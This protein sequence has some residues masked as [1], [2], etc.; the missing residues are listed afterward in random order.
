MRTTMFHGMELSYEV[1]GG[2]AVHDGDII[3]GTAEEAAARAPGRAEP[4]SPRLPRP[5]HLAPYP[6]E[7]L[8]P[9]G[10]IPYV[11]DDDVPMRHKRAVL[12]GIEAWDAKTVLTFVE[13]T[14]ER[15]YLRW[16]VR[17]EGG[18]S[19]AFGRGYDGGEQIMP[20]SPGG[21]GVDIEL[22][23]LGHAIGIWH[24]Q[25]RQDR[26]RY[27]RVFRR[28]IHN[29][30]NQWDQYENDGAD[31]GPYDYRSVMH[32]TFFSE[33]LRRHNQMPMAE[34]IPPGM[35][36][37]GHPEELSPGDID[38]VNRLYG[39][40]PAAWVVST[41]P[42]GLEIVV[43]GIR[44]TAPA[45]FDWEPDSE[46]TLEVPS[47]Q[48]RPGSR[49]LFGR[50]SDG[51]DR[52]HRITA[53]P[54]TTLFQ[55]SFVAQHQVSTSVEPSGAGSVVVSPASP[56][57]YYTLRSPVGLSATPAPG[58]AFRFLNWGVETDFP[59]DWLVW[60][61]HGRSSNP[62]R[63]YVTAG[64]AYRALFVDGP[65]VRIDSNVEQAR[66]EMD[67]WEHSTPVAFPA[68]AYADSGS[69][70]VAAKP[71]E[72]GRRSYRHRFRSWSDGGA[73][74][75]TVAVPQATDTALTLTLDTEYRLT[76]R[77]WYR[78]AGNEIATTPS[79]DDG[80]FA[81]GTEV[82]LRASAG[83]HDEFIGWFGD[84]S[85]HD[86]AV[87]VVMD[88]AQFAEAV[89]ASGRPKTDELQVDAPV[90]VAMRWDANARGWDL[91]G[92]KY[93]VRV[94]T[95]ASELEVEF[96]TRVATPDAVGG[97][98]LTHRS[99]PNWDQVTHENAD[100]VLRPGEVATIAIPRPPERWPAAYFILAR[101]A[102]STGSGTRMLEGTLVARVTGRGSYNRAPYPAGTL[103]DRTLVA[104][105]A[106]LVMDVARAFRDLD[107]DVLTYTAVSSAATVAGVGVWG[108]TLT[109]TPGSAGT[110]T[111]RV[112]ATDTGGSNTA[113]A[114]SF[115]VTVVRTFTDHPIV[116]GVT[117]LKAVH[118]T[119]LRARIDALRSAAG[120][121]QSAWTD[122][123]LRAGETPVRLVHLR[124]LRTALAAV[125]AASGRPAPSWTD[126]SPA[127]GATPIRAAH[128]MEL[129]SLV[130]ALE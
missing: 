25:S 46:H 110:A 77:P 18:C 122:P 38:S 101:G 32:Y 44:M 99:S 103:E 24:E 119:E 14:T 123:V 105:G 11:I 68:D 116:P 72:S 83:P 69:V 79:S 29:W 102:E 75:H 58:S 90:E 93:F 121:E 35:P 60:W 61:W 40:Q 126:A 17:E 95:D 50:W 56:D 15:D 115:T 125:Y 10:I 19:G 80:F 9:G 59:L 42:A 3:L 54:D 128:V 97:L 1:I 33:D 108:S 107:G 12:R 26:D 98:F 86:P 112:T 89:F 70:T 73:L 37:G 106:P 94:P 30:G 100:R 27:V 76:T 62:A 49:F 82:S 91:A 113:A 47:P 67:G 104:S 43:D 16:A 124:E 55:A 127:A 74:A 5:N 57:G 53:T 45:T 52:V 7:V 63:T 66:V 23:E 64:M 39:H 109:V 6:V 118:F 92:K 88:D 84:V 48:F 129:R 2:L 31:I 87:R 4:R 96:L 22:H 71:I 8:W 21:C 28:N 114:Q 81:E 34:T 117:P 111:V 65:I 41:N 78:G 85:G 120:L 20:V 36:M 130:T 51:G 13:R